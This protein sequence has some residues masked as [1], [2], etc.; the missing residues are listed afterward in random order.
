MNSVY[1]KKKLCTIL[2][3]GG[4]KG[5]PNKNIRILAGAPLIAHTIQQ[6]KNSKLFDAIAVSSDSDAILSIAREFGITHLVQRPEALANDTAPKIPAIQHCVT[7]MEAK[8]KTSFEIIC[9][10]D[11]TS[12]FRKIS[13]I[14]ECLKLMEQPGVSNVITAAP[15]RKSPYFNLVETDALGFVRLSKPL[16]DSIKR[17][18]DS[19]KCFDM[20]ASIYVWRRET[21]MGSSSVFQEKTK[22]YEMPPERS[23]EI[24]SELDFQIAQLFS[25][26]L[27]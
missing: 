19:P 17:R 27:K 13:D 25:E 1:L 5:V 26:K 4:S 3:R 6:A 22:L 20:N 7:E 2:A 11:P 10:L 18:Q 21:L 15:S 12:P 16:E 14:A 8:E 23:I 9:D 24:D